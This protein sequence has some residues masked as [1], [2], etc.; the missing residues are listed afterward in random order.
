MSNSIDKTS[1]VNKIAN[2]LSDTD[3]FSGT[4]KKHSKEV[5]A[6]QSGIKEFGATAG[7]FIPGASMICGIA[8][9]LLGGIAAAL[10]T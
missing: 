5:E 1:E 10:G 4:G 3:F 8:S 2:S 9:A 6:L 7:S